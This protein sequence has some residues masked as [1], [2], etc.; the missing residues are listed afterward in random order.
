MKRYVIER[1]IPGV[2]SLSQSQ[3]KELAATSNGAVAKLAGA[4]QWVHSYITADHTFCIY[5]AAS[6]ESVREHSRLAGFPITRVHEAVTVIDP[7]TAFP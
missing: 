5:L 3:Y 1:H 4:I 7:L 2:G 6:D